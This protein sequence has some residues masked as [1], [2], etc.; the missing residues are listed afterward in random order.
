MSLVFVFTHSLNT[1]LYK[2][3]HD[4]S[5]YELEVLSQCLCTSHPPTIVFNM[6][7][8]YSGFTLTFSFILKIISQPDGLG[9]Q[10]N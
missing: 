8:S 5:S 10:A 9:Y 4:S 3:I 2:S 1:M 6:G 7:I